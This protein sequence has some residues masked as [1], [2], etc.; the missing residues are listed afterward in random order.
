MKKIFFLLLMVVTGLFV[1]GQNAKTEYFNKHGKPVD[2]SKT[3]YQRTTTFY[4]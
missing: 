2:K 1:N 4:D 3:A